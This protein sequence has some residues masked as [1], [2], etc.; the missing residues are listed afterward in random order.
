MLGKEDFDD[1]YD[2][3]FIFTD[4]A[5]AIAERYLA[6]PRY[7]EGLESLGLTFTGLMDI[8]PNDLYFRVKRTLDTSV[9][10]TGLVLAACEKLC[11][12]ALD[13]RDLDENGINRG[14]RDYLDDR[15]Y[16]ILDQ[17]Q[18]GI[19]ETGR[20]TGSLDIL[21]K[22]HGLNVAI[23]EGLIHKDQ[24]YLMDHIYK[25]ACRYNPS[26]CRSVYI[27][28]YY[29]NQKFNLAWGNTKKHL[30]QSF[31]GAD[32][33]TGREGLK[34]VTFRKGNIDIWIIGVNMYC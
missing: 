17:T 2:A 7:I 28:E 27:G 8:L 5:E 1:A 19:G 33:D 34:L 20:D 26:G 4:L 16:E 15:G 31:Q 30:L 6:D 32:V 10:L 12:R 22:Q 29:R 18:Q 9:D 21:I 13:Y 25:A 14:V 23:Y 3:E 24:K 11:N